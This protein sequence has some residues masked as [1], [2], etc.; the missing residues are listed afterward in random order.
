M[1]LQN[2]EI[3][4]YGTYWFNP[5]KTACVS[6]STTGPDTR[7][8]PPIE[9]YSVTLRNNIEAIGVTILD[10]QVTKYF[11]N[12]AVYQVV[13]YPGNNNFPVDCP[14]YRSNGYDCCYDYYSGNSIMDVSVSASTV[15][16]LQSVLPIFATY[17]PAK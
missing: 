16:E 3:T 4:G 5:T 13:A 15:E 17:Q 1:A 2:G 8:N 11:G 12:D 14:V 9:A 6:V 7:E 10:W